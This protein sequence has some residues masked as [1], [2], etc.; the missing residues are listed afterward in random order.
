MLLLNIFDVPSSRS[1]V[2]WLCKRPA[3]W[4]V[5]MFLIRAFLVFKV[6]KVSSSE[7]NWL[8]P[9]LKAGLP[10]TLPVV[11]FSLWRSKRFVSYRLQSIGFDFQVTVIN[12]CILNKNKLFVYMS[13]FIKSADFV[14][15]LE[16][17]ALVDV[18]R[19]S[20]KKCQL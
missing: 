5:I 19:T 12:Y 11:S 20:S 18:L 4:L 9:C 14:R 10:L 2:N 8:L 16:S 17:T 13:L 7:S 3:S 15:N 6:C 1:L